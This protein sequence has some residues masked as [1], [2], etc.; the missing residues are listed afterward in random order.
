MIYGRQ[1]AVCLP[2]IATY[3]ASTPRNA[4]RNAACKLS[5]EYLAAD[6][7]VLPSA[8]AHIAQTHCAFTFQS[9]S[10]A[11]HGERGHSIPTNNDNLQDNTLYDL[12]HQ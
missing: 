4:L 6:Y 8:R 1:R 10:R 12:R 5:A 2:R 11:E 9:L 7:T 3:P